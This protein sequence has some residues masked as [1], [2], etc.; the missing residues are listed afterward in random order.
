M[1]SGSFVPM[2]ECHALDTLLVP[3]TCLEP[4]DQHDSEH[5]LT[6]SSVPVPDVSRAPKIL[7]VVG[8]CV[9][10]LISRIGLA[11]GMF[12]WMCMGM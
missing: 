7:S 6:R 8:P 2:C 3:A 11:L 1:D 10:S 4:F 5:L 9:E 12:V